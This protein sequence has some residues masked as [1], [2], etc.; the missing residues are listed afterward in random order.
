MR[1][2]S[3]KFLIAIVTLLVF[4]IITP[5]AAETTL[6]VDDDGGS[7]YTTIQAAVNNASEYDIIDHTI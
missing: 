1:V 5:V 2:I 7:D 3:K 4:S 6:Y